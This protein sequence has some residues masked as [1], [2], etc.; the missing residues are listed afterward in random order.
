MG[1]K[2]ELLVKITGS[3]CGNPLRNEI[4]SAPICGI[5]CAHLRENVF[6]IKNNEQ[7]YNKVSGKTNRTLLRKSAPIRGKMYYSL[8]S[9]VL[10]S[11]LAPANP[12]TASQSAGPL[13]SLITY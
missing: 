8:H 4:K 7:N 10:L 12:T 1:N 5:I 13:K 2:T 11:I 6:C 9:H 3:N